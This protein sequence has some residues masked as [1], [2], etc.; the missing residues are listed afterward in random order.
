MGQAASFID[1]HNPAST[2]GTLGFLRYTTH[3]PALLR[4]QA[5]AIPT[6]APDFDR[7][8]KRY[9][10]RRIARQLNNTRPASDASSNRRV[11]FYPLE[12]RHGKANSNDR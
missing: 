12:L 11:T 1:T 2:I 6:I 9:G 10:V 8:K 7:V 5:L 3:V 4:H